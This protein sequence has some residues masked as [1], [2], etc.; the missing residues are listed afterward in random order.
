MTE[1]LMEKIAEHTQNMQTNH[2][3]VSNED[4]EINF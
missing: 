1:I 2:Q 3:N 4:L